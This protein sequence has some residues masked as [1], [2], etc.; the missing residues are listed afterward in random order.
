[1]GFYTTRFV[2]ADSSEEAGRKAVETV[3]EEVSGYHRP[4]RPWSVTV[5][6]VLEDEAGFET[7]APGAGFSWYQ[8]EETATVNP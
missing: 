1:M 5:E 3:T 4:D 8:D 6:D 2:E 7:H